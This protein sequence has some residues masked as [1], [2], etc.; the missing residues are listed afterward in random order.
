MH[1]LMFRLGYKKYYA[2]GGDWG[3]A[4]SNAMATMYPR[5]VFFCSYIVVSKINEIDLIDISVTCDS[6]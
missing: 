3:S 2:V 1:K 5:C 4:I 6:L